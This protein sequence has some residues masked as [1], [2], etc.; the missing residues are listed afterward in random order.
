MPSIADDP[1]AGHD[2]QDLVIYENLRSI[3]KA[4]CEKPFP[5]PEG[6]PDT[7]DLI[8]RAEGAFKIQ[9][10]QGRSSFP[11]WLENCK[12][13]VLVYL[14]KGQGLLLP[15]IPPSVTPELPEPMRLAEKIYED[16][17]QE[18]V[19]EGNKTL[20]RILNSPE[21]TAIASSDPRLWFRLEI[22]R[23]ELKFDQLATSEATLEAKSALYDHVTDALNETIQR[24]AISRPGRTFGDA[25]LA[26]SLQRAIA[27]YDQLR[28]HISVEP[29]RRELIGNLR[30]IRQEFNDVPQATLTPEVETEFQAKIRALKSE[31]YRRI[32]LKQNQ[33]FDSPF[34][35]ERPPQDRPVSPAI[36]GEFATQLKDLKNHIQAKMKATQ[37][38]TTATPAHHGETQPELPTAVAMQNGRENLKNDQTRSR[39]ASPSQSR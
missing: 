21:A 12:L 13:I 38:L 24:W 26:A 11:D 20:D 7:Q 9:Q 30:M 34:P 25:N 36:I 16:L 31:M 22:R 37:Q 29:P 8:Q 4:Y 28:Y 35:D 39:S 15:E 17:S 6:F 33:F 5:L 18:S 10:H 2:P 1:L 23:T 14:E 27:Q 19:E 32:S 3:Q